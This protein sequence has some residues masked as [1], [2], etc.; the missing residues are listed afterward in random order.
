[1]TMI[2]T[3]IDLIFETSRQHFIG[4]VQT[5]NLYVVGLESSAINHIKNS[6]RSS[7]NDM[8][9][10]LKFCNVLTNIGTSNASVALNVHVIAQSDHNFLDLLGQLTSGGEY[11]GLRGFD[12][13]IQLE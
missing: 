4:L 6:S 7:H 9:P 12:R 1:M 2:V 13:Y 5:E 3:L 11:Q 10:F 8:N